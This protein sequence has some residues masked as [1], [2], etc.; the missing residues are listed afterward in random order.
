M[1]MKGVTK[2]VETWGVLAEKE[3]QDEAEKQLVMVQAHTSHLCI[4]QRIRK[5]ECCLR[6]HI[7]IR[8]KCKRHKSNISISHRAVYFISSKCQSHV[9]RCFQRIHWLLW[10]PASL[11][12]QLSC[13]FSIFSICLS[14]S[15]FCSLQVSIIVC[16][17]IFCRCLLLLSVSLQ[18]S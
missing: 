12:E 14:L 10:P 15:I 6:S 5:A 8:N 2:Q 17:E 9:C 1:G 16:R 3:R 7:K 13:G 18:D 11:D 4:Q